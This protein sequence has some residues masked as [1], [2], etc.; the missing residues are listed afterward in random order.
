MEQIHFQQACIFSRYTQNIKVLTLVY[1]HCRFKLTLQ[2]PKTRTTDIETL[3]KQV[4][5]M[6]KTKLRMGIELIK[7]KSDMTKMK[8]AL[9]QKQLDKG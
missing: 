7:L 8:M 4:L 1:K 3:Q 5:Q 9:L 6:K 2:I